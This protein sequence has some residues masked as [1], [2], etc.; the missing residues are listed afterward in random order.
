MQTSQF[1]SVKVAIKQDKTGYV[2]TLSIHPDEIPDEILRDFVG[3]RYQVVMVRLNESERPMDRDQELS[4]DYVRMS[5]ILCRDKKFHDFLYETKG[6]F[7]PSEYE[8]TGWLRGYLEVT[9][10]SDIPKSQIAINR[11]LSINKEFELWKQSA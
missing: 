3:S 2:L 8:T 1:E 10:R 4:K 9:S 7:P 11:L 6:V 5:G